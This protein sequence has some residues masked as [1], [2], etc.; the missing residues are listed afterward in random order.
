MQA[1]PPQHGREIAAALKK[2]GV[3]TEYVPEYAKELVWDGRQVASIP[4]SRA[5]LSM[6]RYAPF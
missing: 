2:A 6:R 3:V 4:R 5:Y 1:R